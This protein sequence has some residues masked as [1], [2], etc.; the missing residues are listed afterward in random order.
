MPE[1][2]ANRLR[3]GQT[4]TAVVEALD[5]RQFTGRVT[6]INAALDTATRATIV[7][8]TVSNPDG[9]IRAGMFATAQVSLGTTERGLFVPREALVEDP[10]TNS[11]RVFTVDGDS[12]HLRV[13]QPGPAADRMVRV[14]TGVT[15]GE[16]VVTRG[17]E[18]L[19]DGA[20]VRPAAR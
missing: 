6:A 12:A 11:F 19:F 4:V 10:N 3:V 5:N 18:Q 2:E 15:A 1:F 8:A 20:A 13:I 9:A 7:E 14:L 16:Q 17:T